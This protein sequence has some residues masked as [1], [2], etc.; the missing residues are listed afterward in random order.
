MKKR[1][2]RF[3]RALVVTWLVH[4]S[5]VTGG[6]EDES[7]AKGKAEPGPEGANCD[8]KNDESCSMT[9]LQGYASEGA[10]CRRDDISPVK[11][12]PSRVGGF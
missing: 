12:S 8:Q 3:L 11:S 5:V 9:M 7:D 1:T 4:L 6:C 10:S 2:Q